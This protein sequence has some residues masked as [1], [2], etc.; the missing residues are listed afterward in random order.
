MELTIDR[1]G[2]AHGALT[3]GRFASLLIEQAMNPKPARPWIHTL[4]LQDLFEKRQIQLIARVGRGPR[5]MLFKPAK[6]SLF[7][8]L[9][10][11]CGHGERDNLRQ[12]AIL[13]L[14]QPS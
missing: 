11:Y 14:C 10:E 4:E 7:E 2:T 3:R 12:P 1:H 9:Q 13:F 8:R 5:S 6:P